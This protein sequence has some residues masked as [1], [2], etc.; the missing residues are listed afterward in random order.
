[1]L[2]LVKIGVVAL[3][4][5]YADNNQL[6]DGQLL[7]AAFVATDASEVA[8]HTAQMKNTIKNSKGSPRRLFNAAIWC[9][10]NNKTDI[11]EGW[12]ATGQTIE[13]NPEIRNELTDA[14]TP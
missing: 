10:R 3:R 5:A 1:M 9:V 11:A 8:G 4:L 13:L 6:T 2:E 14:L 7:S 12:A